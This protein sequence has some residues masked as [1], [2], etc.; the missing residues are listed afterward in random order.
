MIIKGN[1]E[2]VDYFSFNPV[3]APVSFISL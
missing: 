1:E 3:K 2:T